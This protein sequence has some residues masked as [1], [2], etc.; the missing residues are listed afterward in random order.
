[1]SLE[2]ISKELHN[3]R[4]KYTNVFKPLQCLVK[5]I[6]LQSKLYLIKCLT[7]LGRE[8]G[9]VLL[10]NLLKLKVSLDKYSIISII[11]NF[12]LHSKN[13]LKTSDWSLTPFFSDLGK[14]VWLSNRPNAWL[15]DYITEHLYISQETASFLKITLLIMIY[16]HWL[17]AEL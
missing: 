16:K 14:L 17:F 7:N 6:V 2:N 5:F 9:K 4:K 15:H 12:L 13:S 10:E 3:K 8:W 11:V 1:M